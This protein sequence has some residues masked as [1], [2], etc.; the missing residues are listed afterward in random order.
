MKA[1][2]RDRLQ[3]I[4]EAM[5]DERVGG[6]RAL[7]A[8]DEGCAKHPEIGFEARWGAMLARWEAFAAALPG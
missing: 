2:R 6:P 3:A 4:R 5:R 1:A 8:A 7:H